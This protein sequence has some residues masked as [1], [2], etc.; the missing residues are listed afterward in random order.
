MHRREYDKQGNPI[1]TTKECLAQSDLHKAR[2]SV[3][4]END[5]IAEMAAREID[6]CKRELSKYWQDC[7]DVQ[8]Q[9]AGDRLMKTW[10]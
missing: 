6:R 3:F 1:M 7:S 8:R 4:D 5:E 2:L 9:R 10:E